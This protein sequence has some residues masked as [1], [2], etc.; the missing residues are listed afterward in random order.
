MLVSSHA[1]NG[2]G[3]VAVICSRARKFVPRMDFV[4]HRRAITCVRFHPRM[5]RVKE[6]NEVTCLLAIA[7]KDRAVSFWLSS[8]PKAFLALHELLDDEVVDLSWATNSIELA[9]CSITGKIKFVLF[10]DSEIGRLLTQHEQT[11]VL[12]RLHGEDMNETSAPSILV[13]DPDMFPYLVKEAELNEKENVSSSPEKPTPKKVF[14]HA[15]MTSSAVISTTQKEL[16]SKDGRRRIVP[17]CI[18]LQQPDSNEDAVVMPVPFRGRQENLKRDDDTQENVQIREGNSSVVTSTTSPESSPISPE[19]RAQKQISVQDLKLGSFRSLQSDVKNKDQNTGSTTLAMESLDPA[20]HTTASEAQVL[21]SNVIRANVSPD[22]STVAADKPS[23]VPDK[24]ISAIYQAKSPLTDVDSSVKSAKMTKAKKLKQNA[25][26]MSNSKGATTLFQS[27]G[28]KKKKRRVILEDDDDESGLT[29]YRMRPNEMY[30]SRMYGDGDASDIDAEDKDCSDDEVYSPVEVIDPAKVLDAFTVNHSHFEVTVTNN[31]SIGPMAPSMHMLNFKYSTNEETDKFTKCLTDPI[32]CACVSEELV[33]VACA[34]DTV[35]VYDHNGNILEMPFVVDASIAQLKCNG[36]MV[37][38][39]TCE[40]TVSV[41]D[42]RRMK[43][44]LWN[45]QLTNLFRAA[46]VKL[47]LAFLSENGTPFIVT[48]AHK[49][50]MFHAGFNGWV[51]AQPPRW[52]LAKRGTTSQTPAVGGSSGSSS[53]HTQTGVMSLLEDLCSDNRMKDNSLAEAVDRTRRN[54]PG[55]CSAV[56][57]MVHYSTWQYSDIQQKLAMNI[58]SGPDVKK[59]LLGVISELS[60]IGNEDALRAKLDELL[61]NVGLPSV[62]ACFMTSSQVESSRDPIERLGLN[63]RQLLHE[64][65]DIV[66]KNVKNQKIF[67]EYNQI[68]KQ[69]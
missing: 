14:K 2:E 52:S 60:W 42:M 41:F 3:P 37:M 17:V 44:V 6:T 18:G 56:E 31:V 23:A 22:S 27:Q 5:V 43:S 20:V 61:D 57:N 24:G 16:I 8:R 67:S 39:L 29:A 58:A 47:K 33:V 34:D 46:D 21:S 38:V 66:A 4:G 12:Q 35:H 59:W 55:T 40:V 50:Y 65:L 25:L 10:R 13:S 51:L 49:A 54:D 15:N 36:H 28:A 69:L 19:Q 45:Y 1:V 63:R 9:A 7:S 68:L 32:V 26:K 62:A 30:G 64:A 53:S 11:T 48:T